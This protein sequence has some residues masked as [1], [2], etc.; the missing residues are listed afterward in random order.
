MENE[1][2]IEQLPFTQEY[3]DMIARLKWIADS[4]LADGELMPVVHLYNTEKHV[5]DIIGGA[6]VDEKSKDFFASACKLKAREIGADL[7]VFISESWTLDAASEEDYRKHMRSNES[8][9]NHPKARE[10]V[11]FQIE[12][13]TGSW[14]GRASIKNGTTRTTDELSFVKAD[15]MAGRFS[16]IIPQE[17]SH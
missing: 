16:G 13:R 17:V 5:A 10:I 4:I 12:T 15:K 7:S 3:K 14:M 9:S 2:T 8:L 11:C 6:F 1:L